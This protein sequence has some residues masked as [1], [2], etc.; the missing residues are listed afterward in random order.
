[1][2]KLKTKKPKL[3]KPSIK[4]LRRRK[5][6][7]EKVNEAINDVPRITNDTLADHRE[8]VLSSARKYIYPLQHSKHS[9]VRISITLFVVVVIGFLAICSLDLYKFQG[10]SGFIYDVTEI[11]PFPAAKVDGSWVSYESY[12]FE[13]RRNMHY[14][15]SQQAA[16]F[17]TKDGKAQLNSL[18]QESLSYAIQ[19]A[20][21]NKLANENHVSVSGQAVDNQIELLKNQNLL[22]SSNAVFKE[23]LNQY[24]GW[25][26]NDFKTQ[27]KQ[28]MLEQA[29][30]AKL[31]TSA[32]SEA[33]SI[34]KQLQSGADFGTLATKY[35][36]DT[37]TK[38]NGG[39]YSSVI[40]PND[41][42]VAP[43]ITS[44]LF[45]LKA[46]QISGIINA[47]YT[48]DIVK[49]ISRSGNSVQAAD[50]QINLNN[51]STYIAPIEKHNPP[52]K[53]IST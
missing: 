8:D 2:K 5:T 17:K 26:V 35:S 37:Q 18:K 20:L 46:G 23:V 49:V 39:Q 50:I 9:I 32:S 30:V 22:G 7:E 15:V 52:H 41:Q 14:Y 10:T 27:L 43:E 38:S 51:I 53:F 1:M 6:I 24:Y 4:V 31:D 34:L 13:L 33:S 42:Q 44:Q 21:V 40:T 19:S 16:N 48:L 25:D 45:N 3:K 11:F 47:G 28:E 12:L 29:V 36:D